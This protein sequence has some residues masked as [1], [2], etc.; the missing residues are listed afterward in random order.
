MSSE[1]EIFSY[2]EL[3]QE[4]QHS[5]Y[6]LPGCIIYLSKAICHILDGKLH[7][8]DGFLKKHTVA[9]LW[10]TRV[11]FSNCNSNSYSSSM[12]FL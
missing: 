6:D 12:L 7:T 5:N 8:Q 9:M 3:H 2:V 1:G 10:M 11:Y 4:K